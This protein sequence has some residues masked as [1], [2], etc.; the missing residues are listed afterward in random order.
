MKRKIV[1]QVEEAIPF[2]ILDSRFDGFMCGMTITDTKPTQKRQGML[3]V[4]QSYFGTRILNVARMVSKTARAIDLEEIGW[5]TVSPSTRGGWRILLTTTCVPP[6]QIESYFEE[7]TS[8]VQEW[9]DLVLGF[10]GSSALLMDAKASI[11][12]VIHAITI[13]KSATLW[14]AVTSSVVYNALLLQ[15][16]NVVAVFKERTANAQVECRE[17]SLHNPPRRA[18]GFELLTCGKEGCGRIPYSMPVIGPDGWGRFNFECSTCG[19]T[20]RVP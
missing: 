11:L 9:F 8:L 7:A 6:T 17:I 4:L 16:A 20:Y 15:N 14:D 3:K 2:F 5:Y 13:D 19:W 1:C 18:F 12:N 10:R